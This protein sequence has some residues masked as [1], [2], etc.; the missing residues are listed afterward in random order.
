M[1]A[2]NPADPQELPDRS[3]AT[4]RVAPSTP[5][6]GGV[7]MCAIAAVQIEKGD[8]CDKQPPPS[9]NAAEGGGAAL[10]LIRGTI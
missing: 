9:F 5:H 7:F 2:R 10:K 6:V 4:R 3:P 1:F 8:G